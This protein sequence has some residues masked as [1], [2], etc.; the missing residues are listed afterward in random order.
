MCEMIQDEIIRSRE[1][2]Q[3]LDKQNI[4]KYLRKQYYTISVYNNNKNR[5]VIKLKNEQLKCSLTKIS[6]CMWQKIILHGDKWKTSKWKN[7]FNIF[8][9]LYLLWNN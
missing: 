9:V 6:T 2:F 5:I 7:M 3:D 1:V 8:V 4:Y